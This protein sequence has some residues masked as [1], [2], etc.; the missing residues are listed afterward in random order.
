MSAGELFLTD[1]LKECSW[2]L[3]ERQSGAETRDNDGQVV[4]WGRSYW[5]IVCRYD[6]LSDS[7]FRALTAWLARRKGSRVIF[8]AYRPDRPTPL[9]NSAMSNTGLGIAD[10]DI[11][12]ATI[13]LTGLG[14]TVLSPGDMVS[15]LSDTGRYWIGEITVGATPTAGAATVSVWP[16]PQEPHA[17]APAPRL[18]QPIGHFQLVGQTEIHEPSSRLRTVAFTAKQITYP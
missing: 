7:A 15:Y 18:R 12:A 5:Q 8:S 4:A 2:T 10:V 9:L 13:D 3:I 6:N 14:S 17:S 16:P 11:E 1:C